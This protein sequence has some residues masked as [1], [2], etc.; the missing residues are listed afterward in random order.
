MG[1]MLDLDGM[2]RRIKALVIFRAGQDKGLRSEAALPLFHVFS[3][4]PVSRGKFAQLTGLGERTSR[5]LL[6]RLL[7]TGLPVSDTALGP[8]RFGLPLDSLQFLFPELYP[9]AATMPE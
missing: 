1:K 8:V 6:S 3:A 7:S 9:E 5:S 4:G 2:K